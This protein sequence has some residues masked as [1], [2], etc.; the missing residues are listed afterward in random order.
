MSVPSVLD[1]RVGLP[2]RWPSWKAWRIAQ[3][4]RSP[5]RNV[6]V[7][8]WLVVLGQPIT[9]E[10]IG[11]ESWSHW[12]FAQRCPEHVGYRDAVNHQGGAA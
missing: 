11:W 3:Q 9:Y 4:P 5:R 2:I 10:W 6:W 8:R 1:H 7:R 12:T